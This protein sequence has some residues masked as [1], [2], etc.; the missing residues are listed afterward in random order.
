MRWLVVLSSVLS[1]ISIALVVFVVV[2]RSDAPSVSEDDVNRL[3]FLRSKLIGNKGQTGPQGPQGPQG[4]QGH[5][6]IQGFDGLQG[7]RGLRGVPG[8]DGLDGPPGPQGEQGPPGMP[9]F[10]PTIL[11]SGRTLDVEQAYYWPSDGAMPDI[12]LPPPGDWL[13]IRW[14]QFDGETVSARLVPAQDIFALSPSSHRGHSSILDKSLEIAEVQTFGGVVRVY[15]GWTYEGLLLLTSSSKHYDLIDLEVSRLTMATQVATSAADIAIQPAGEGNYEITYGG[16]F[17]SEANSPKIKIPEERWL[18]IQLDFRTGT[19]TDSLHIIDGERLR[20]LPPASYGD[21]LDGTNALL[22]TEIT[23]V[24]IVGKVS[25]ATVRLG[26]T[27]ENY[28]L[29]ST[30]S[31]LHGPRPIRLFK[32]AEV[33]EVLE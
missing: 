9:A 17:A 32:L 8:R 28:L 16:T 26:R 11:S 23:G 6:G 3:I 2:S 24:T 10:A 15:A 13:L 19:I 29:V 20:S 27:K 1:V 5:P 21:V 18:L 33:I 12:R 4:R 14:K 31:A 30:S 22:V 25:V 7:E